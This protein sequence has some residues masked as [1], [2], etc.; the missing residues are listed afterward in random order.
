MQLM[1]IPVLPCEQFLQLGMMN[2]DERWECP[3][4]FTYSDF[5]CCLV[6]LMVFPTH[7]GVNRHAV[8]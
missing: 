8:S 2:G 5:L 7:L 3:G 6:E 4:H 1:Y